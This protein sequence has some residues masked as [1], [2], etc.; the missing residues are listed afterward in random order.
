MFCLFGNSVWLIKYSFSKS[1][2]SSGLI[3]R[4]LRFWLFMGGRL[5][6]LPFTNAFRVFHHVLGLCMSFFSLWTTLFG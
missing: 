4:V 3:I 6:V 2:L 1:A 5:W